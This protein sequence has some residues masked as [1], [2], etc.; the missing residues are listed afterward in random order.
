MALT[1]Q[2]EAEL[3]ELSKAEGIDPAFARA[4]APPKGAVIDQPPTPGSEDKLGGIKAVYGKDWTPYAPG[5]QPISQTGDDRARDDAAT[6]AEAERV[7]GM[8]D[9]RYSLV[10]QILAL[11]PATNDPHGDEAAKAKYQAGQKDAIFIYE[12]PVDVVRKHLLENPAMLRAVSPDEVPS[13]G[14]IQIMTSDSSLYQSTADYMYKTASE[15]ADAKGQKI[16]RYSQAPWVQSDQG[17]LKT[18]SLKLKGA[19]SE[20]ANQAQ[21]FVLGV[22]DMGA[23]GIGRAGQELT[24]PT[25]MLTQPRLGLNESVPQSSADVNG[26]TEQEYP[27]S[28]L[29]GQALGMLSPRSVF[30]HLWGMVE[31]GGGKLAA[32]AAK[33]RLGGLAARETAPVLKSAAGAVGDAATGYVAAGLGQA[34][35]EMVHAAGQGE[36][37]DLGE[38]AG[39]VK[40]VAG[41]GGVLAGLGS[42]VRRLAGSG[43]DFIRDSPR[44]TG[45]RG[46]GAVRRTEP[47]MEYRLGREPRLSGET[48]A[49]VKRANATGDQPGDLLA[50]EIAPPIRDAAQANTRAARTQSD[51]ERRAFQATPEGSTAQPV[52][53]LERMSLE[54]L[55]DHHQPQPDGSLRPVDSGFREAH[56][57]FNRHID[58]VSLEPVKGAVELSA[59]EA[60]AFLGARAR[61]QLVKD[62]IEQATR[63]R[64]SKPVDRNAYLANKS[65][66]A[67][68]G[69]NEEIEADIDDLI[70]SD[71]QGVPRTVDKRS[72]EYKAAEKQVLRERADTE[73]TL[74]PFGGSLGEY[75]KQR[76]KDRVFVKPAA[77]DARR[78]DTLVAGLKDPDLIEAAK[79]DRQQFPKNGERGGYELMRRRQDDR[80]AKAEK[81]EQTVAP[82]GDAFRPIAGLYHA[83]PGEKQLV[84]QVK[85]LADQ[86]GVRQQLDRMRGL[87]ETLAIQNRASWRDASGQT[88]LRPTNWADAAQLRGA[89]PA[90]KSLEGPLG[91]LR[92]SS[93]G[94]AALLGGGETE[95]RQARAESGARGR[96]EV[97][98]DKRLKEIAAEKAAAAQEDERRK[99]ETIR[100]RR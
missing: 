75:L 71:K 34:G 35:Q 66:K 87:Q 18:L 40:S 100:R 38:A 5:G 15:A 4:A 48:K 70:G 39:R 47:N 96:Y 89:F 81:V 17:V 83:H 21:A 67:R 58:G 13:V 6:Q 16:I 33:T 82:G 30:N 24:E 79:Y 74:E 68:D 36:L 92:G 63:E 3:A 76:G 12:P 19:G 28:Y 20:A 32:A 62:D 31:T 55:R 61:H 57:V 93:A 43:A 98:R 37:P 2:E 85:G 59:D 23:A 29:A 51:I 73:T 99:T 78:A 52:T 22:D 46:P 49:L 60:S 84:D 7:A 56:Q 41:T 86:A 27:K 69:I 42:G 64:L 72:A 54:K 8:L 65:A 94:R 80:V 45:P 91:P 95:A 26:W 1:P 44:F 10:P 9:P 53:H 50:E 11:Q 14:D 90:L 25:T 77:Y 97:A 88:H